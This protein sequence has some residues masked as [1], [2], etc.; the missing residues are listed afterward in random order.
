MNKFFFLL[1]FFFCSWI[2]PV[3][4]EE[5]GQSALS[6]ATFAGGCF[7]CVEAPFEKILG[8]KKVVSGYTGG[9]IINPT[10]KEVSSGTTGHIESIEILFDPNEVSYEK[11]LDV[12]WQQIDPTDNDGQF[13]DR[14]LQYRSVIF[15][16][17]EKQR[18]LAEDSKKQLE[19]SSRFDDPVVTEIIP[20]TIFYQ[21]ED[22]H[23]DYYKKNNLKYKYYRY[24]SGRDQFLDKIWGNNRPYK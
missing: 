9:S 10:Y 5:A 12:F 3:L 7:W 6:K 15:Y 21:A 22:Y 2:L 18:Q 4:G 8:V 11:L 17:D 23:Q 19:D 1:W 14:G 13:V 24:R 20:A 16:H